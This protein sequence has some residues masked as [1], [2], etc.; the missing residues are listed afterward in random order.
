[1]VCL[2]YHGKTAVW[3]PEYSSCQ[4]PDVHLPGPAC[5]L[6]V[7]KP[8]SLSSQADSRDVTLSTAYAALHSSHREDEV[9]LRCPVQAAVMYSLQQ[10]AL[11][12]ELVSM[13]HCR[14]LVT[15]QCS[16]Y[17]CFVCCG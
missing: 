2:L 3:K 10:A 5:S 12:L 16:L 8:G 14:A 7:A 11:A 4:S 1:M 13:L 15:Q 6:T 17:V 9:K